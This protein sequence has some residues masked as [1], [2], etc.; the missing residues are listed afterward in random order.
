MVVCSL[1]YDKLSLGKYLY[2]MLEIDNVAI[3]FYK[4]NNASSRILYG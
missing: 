3:Q 1:D 2:S 4:A